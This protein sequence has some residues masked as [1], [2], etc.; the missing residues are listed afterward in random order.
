MDT[1]SGK[2]KYGTYVFT[3]VAYEVANSFNIIAD[4]NGLNLNAGVSKTFRFKGL[5]PIA[6]TLGL[7]DLTKYSG[8]GVRIIGAIGTGFQI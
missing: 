6:V 5:P 7:A 1:D 8:D 4:W 3:N 2:G